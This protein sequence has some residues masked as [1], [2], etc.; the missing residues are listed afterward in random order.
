MKIIL[1]FTLWTIIFTCAQSNSFTFLENSELQPGEISFK[2]DCEPNL[3]LTHLAVKANPSKVEKGKPI[4]FKG[5][6][7]ANTD[8]KTSKILVK[9]K[10]NDVDSFEQEKALENTTKAHFSF[11]YSF[12]VQVPSFVPQGKYNIMLYIVDEKGD[13][14]SCLNALFEF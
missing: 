12:D 14:L 6:V 3:P 10:F 8:V 11:V 9:A 13:H 1:L 2:K 5:K 7:Y 4:T